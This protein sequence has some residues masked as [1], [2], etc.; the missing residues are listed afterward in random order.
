[1]ESMNARTDHY[2][3]IGRVVAVV[4]LSLIASLAWAQRN[5]CEGES[6]LK[7]SPEH[8]N[9]YVRGYIRGYYGGYFHGCQEGTKYSS[10]DVESRA[11]KSPVDECLDKKLDFTKGTEL[12]KEI[13]RF[14]IRY[15]EHRILLI[16]EILEE[17]GKGRSIEDIHNHP[18]F[19]A[20]NS[21]NPS[22]AT[23]E[24]RK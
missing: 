24:R 17:L 4:F 15:P 9:D 2:I 7:W 16:N 13:T 19:P 22:E 1:M 6:W 21:S 5:C 23:N 18:P 3:P 11:G 8:R 20:H 14:Y 12:S 10:G